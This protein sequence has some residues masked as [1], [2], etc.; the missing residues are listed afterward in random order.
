M[1]KAQNI[2]DKWN[3]KGAMIKMDSAM[4]IQLGY[5]FNPADLLCY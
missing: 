5:F 2:K 3:A 4:K 1:K